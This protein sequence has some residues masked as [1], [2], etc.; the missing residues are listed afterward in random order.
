M[1]PETDLRFKDV[2]TEH[3]PLKSPAARA[4][5][6]P[7]RAS[8]PTPAE[9]TRPPPQRHAAQMTRSIR[10]RVGG[11]GWGVEGGDRKG[12][13]DRGG[14]RGGGDGRGGRG[15]GEGGE[16]GEDEAGGKGERCQDVT[17]SQV[18]RRQ[19]PFSL[20]L[21]ASPRLEPPPPWPHSRPPPP[22]SPR[23]ARRRRFLPARRGRLARRRQ[24]LCPAVRR[25]FPCFRC[26]E[27]VFGRPRSAMQGHREGGAPATKFP[28]R[29]VEVALE[30]AIPGAVYFHE[31]A[32]KPNPHS[33]PKARPALAASP[34]TSPCIPTAPALPTQAAAAPHA[35]VPAT[36]GQPPAPASQL[37]K[38]RRRSRQTAPRI[39][40]RT[41]A[42]AAGAQERQQ[43]DRGSGGH[44]NYA[45]LSE[46]AIND[47]QLEI[48]ELVWPSQ[49]KTPQRSI[50][51]FPLLMTSCRRVK[52]SSIPDCHIPS[53]ANIAIA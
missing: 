24:H 10:K 26:P 2:A 44:V 35:H 36:S 13:R 6:P 47:P 45:T 19:P 5:P 25:M 9:V 53:H 38:P 8:P 42:A 51:S 33:R 32:P 16:G 14:R 37:L 50:S 4:G 31:P 21:R 30:S 12:G 22:V 48:D 23:R 39:T 49:G 27:A 40:V 28:S 43:V 41:G 34:A 15:R 7:L 11:G 17:V 3:V 1:I 18:T 52:S 46:A 20:R 29:R